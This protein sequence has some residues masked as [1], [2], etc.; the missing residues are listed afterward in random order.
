MTWCRVTQ[1]DLESRIDF[2]ALRLATVE[3]PAERRAV[4][5]Q[6]RDLITQRTPE[7]VREM[8]RELGL[9]Q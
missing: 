3:T 8:E 2:A 4:W 5:A 9:A 1:P 6:L 7:R